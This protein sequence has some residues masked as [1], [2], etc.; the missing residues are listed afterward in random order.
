MMQQDG[1]NSS[2]GVTAEALPAAQQ[3]NSVENPE[4]RLVIVKVPRENRPFNRENVVDALLGYGIEFEAMGRFS[5][6]LEF[7]VLLENRSDADRL[8]KEGYMEISNMRGLPCGCVV[9]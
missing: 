7:Q 4:E 8:A 9:C 2:P 6:G 1:G 5:G 3:P